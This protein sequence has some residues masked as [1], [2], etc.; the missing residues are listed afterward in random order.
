[1][2]CSRRIFIFDKPQNI[3][4]PTNLKSG[5]QSQMGYKLRPVAQDVHASKIHDASDIEKLHFIVTL[6]KKWDA[7]N[8]LIFITLTFW[9]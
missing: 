7:N 3:C 5:L 6:Y 9:R 1:M 2:K 8:I 4:N